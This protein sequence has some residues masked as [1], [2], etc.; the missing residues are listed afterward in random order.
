[1]SDDDNNECSMGRTI[2][3]CSAQSRAGLAL[4]YAKHETF[5][6]STVV[7]FGSVRGL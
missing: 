6:P 1:V 7:L 2:L 3:A 4:L 5:E